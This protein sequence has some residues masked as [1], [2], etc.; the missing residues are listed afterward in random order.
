VG[1]KFNYKNAKNI[2]DVIYYDF[3][4][5]IL[6]DEN[7]SISYNIIHKFQT[8]NGLD[9]A[10][11]GKI[12][13]ESLIEKANDYKEFVQMLSELFSEPDLIKKRKLERK[14]KL[15][16]YFKYVLFTQEGYDLIKGKHLFTEG[17][18]SKTVL[19][20]SYEEDGNLIFDKTLIVA[21]ENKVTGIRNEKGRVTNIE[22]FDSFDKYEENYFINSIDLNNLSEETSAEYVRVNYSR[23]LEYIKQ[24]FSSFYK[25]IS[26]PIDNMTPEE[27]IAHMAQVLEVLHTAQFGE[28]KSKTF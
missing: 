27:K 14:I 19:T 21:P 7:E 23:I 17:E 10:V 20:N 12:F 25:N 9:Y 13:A 22:Y 18:I 6:K 3:P 15:S 24:N 4:I 8:E 11:I 16:R 26:K 5:I 1:D 2:S 28:M